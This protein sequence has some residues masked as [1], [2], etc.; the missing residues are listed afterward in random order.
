MAQYLNVLV[1]DYAQA[2]TDVPDLK[3]VGQ[4]TETGQQM[5]EN[6]VDVNVRVEACK[7]DTLVLFT[8]NDHFLNGIRLACKRGLIHPDNLTIYEY[9]PGNPAPLVSN[10][11]KRGR[12]DRW[13]TCF[14]A[15]EDALCQL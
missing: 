4:T 3:V 15:I 2:V 9:L 6:G 11:D 12:L 1:G 7:S 8:N 14:T 10:V 5:V 13:P